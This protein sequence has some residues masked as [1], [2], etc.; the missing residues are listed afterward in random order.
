MDIFGKYCICSVDVITL[1]VEVESFLHYNTMNKRHINVFT[2]LLG[3][4]D[5]SSYNI[6]TQLLSATNTK[7]TQK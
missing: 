6:L 7:R 1:F 3:I 4:R 2:Y 5:D